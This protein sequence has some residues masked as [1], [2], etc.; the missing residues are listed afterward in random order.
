MSLFCSATIY[1]CVLSNAH[2]IFLL[3]SPLVI[4][5]VIHDPSCKVCGQ[6]ELLRNLYRAREVDQGFRA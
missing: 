1:C 2:F 6:R 4:N 3:L 5:T